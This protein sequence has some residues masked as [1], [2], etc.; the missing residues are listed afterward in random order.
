MKNA[1]ERLM[2]GATRLLVLALGLG[3]TATGWADADYV[4]VN[5]YYL[6][7]SS[8]AYTAVSMNDDQS[9]SNNASLEGYSSYAV[10][11]K[12]WSDVNVGN[13][14]AQSVKTYDSSVGL[15]SASDITVTVSGTNGG[16]FSGAGFD[17]HILSGYIDDNESNQSPLVTFANIPFDYY[18]VVVYFASSDGLKVS[19]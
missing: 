4:N 5:F 15:V 17:H 11:G 7:N 10:A 3:L 14:A 1:V 6:Y 8:Y 19:G 2:S 16:Y 9:D 18:R 13:S 12:Y